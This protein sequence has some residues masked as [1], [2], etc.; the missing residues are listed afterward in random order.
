MEAEAE[1]EGP[2]SGVGGVWPSQKIW[3]CGPESDGMYDFGDR[4][5]FLGVVETMPIPQTS[6]LFPIQAAR[7]VKRF[8][9]LSVFFG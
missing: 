8:F 1:V 5:Y 7:D 9:W 3:N 4:A 2:E 6:H